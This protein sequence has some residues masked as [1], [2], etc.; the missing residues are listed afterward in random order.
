MPL[1][2]P[3]TPFSAFLAPQYQVKPVCEEGVHCTL[4][5]RLSA[6]RQGCGVQTV[7]QDTNARGLNCAWSVGARTEP[8]CGCRA[9]CAPVAHRPGPRHASCFPT[10]PVTPCNAKL[11]RLIPWLTLVPIFW[12]CEGHPATPRAA[13][14]AAAGP[15][16]APCTAQCICSCISMLQATRSRPRLCRWRGRARPQQQRWRRTRAAFGT[17]ATA[18][19]AAAPASPAWRQH[20]DTADAAG[21]EAAARQPVRGI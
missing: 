7:G 8:M 9:R 6:T 16:A 14:A 21:R 19:T 13:N 1:R 5:Q 4:G 11:I 20:R 2:S 17:P 3:A 10:R 12:T 15:A 18:A